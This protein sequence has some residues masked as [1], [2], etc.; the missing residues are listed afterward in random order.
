MS[1]RSVVLSVEL[2]NG[3][4][5]QGKVSFVDKHMN[6]N[7]YDINVDLEKYPQFVDLC[8]PGGHEELLHPRVHCSLRAHSPQRTGH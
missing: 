2:K 8:D 5:I 7:L 1:D 4:V 6:F 3:L